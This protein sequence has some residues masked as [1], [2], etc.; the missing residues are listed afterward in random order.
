MDFHVK[1]FVLSFVQLSIVLGVLPQAALGQVDFWDLPPI[2]YSDTAATDEISKMAAALSDGTLKID[3]E[4]V[5]GN[6]AFQN[7]FASQFPRT[8]N[9]D[10]LAEFRLYGR[11]FKNRCSYMVYSDAFRG[12]PASVKEKVSVGMKRVLDGTHPEIDWI[13][14][15]ERKRIFHILEETLEGWPPAEK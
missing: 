1:R 12:L 8:G 11:I 9:G 14:G 15:S 3:G 6:P 7:A 10:S 4:G 13:S 5:E 2:R